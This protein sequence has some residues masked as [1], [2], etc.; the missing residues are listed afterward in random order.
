MI[1]WNKT[2][3]YALSFIHSKSSYKLTPVNLSI[4]IVGGKFQ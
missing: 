4:N 1:N 3:G 2:Y